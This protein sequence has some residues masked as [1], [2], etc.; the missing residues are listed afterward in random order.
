VLL[1]EELRLHER[2]VARDEA[3]LLEWLGRTG[4]VVYSVAL[5]H[6]GRVGLAEDLTEALFLEV[7][8]HPEAFHPD[9]GP[10]TL[11]LIRRMSVDVFSP[12]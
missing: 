9:K 5:S 8:R 4:G 11:Q 6:T 1:D 2:V 10:L 3:A 7:W 12:S